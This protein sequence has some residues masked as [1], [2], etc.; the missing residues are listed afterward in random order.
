[1]PQA[2][3]YPSPWGPNLR[4]R[5]GRVCASRNF[6]AGFLVGVVVDMRREQVCGIVKG[7]I[8][9]LQAGQERLL[10]SFG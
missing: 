3:G 5:G 6:F 7:V 2:I 9:A 8:P 4:A 10:G 1:M